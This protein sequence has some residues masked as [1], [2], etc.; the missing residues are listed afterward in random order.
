MLHQN[1]IVS[2]FDSVTVEDIKKNN[3]KDVSIQSLVEIFFHKHNF[4]IFFKFPA[5]S[6]SKQYKLRALLE[7]K[8]IGLR[9]LKKKDL[10]V[11]LRVY[12]DI[13]RLPLK[14][15]FFK[16]IRVSGYF[17]I[18]EDY[19]HL[20]YFENFLLSKLFGQKFLPIFLKTNTQFFF[21]NSLHYKQLRNKLTIFKHNFNNILGFFPFFYKFH[22]SYMLFVLYLRI[23]DLFY[24]I[25]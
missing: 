5:S 25:N 17:I 14:D 10:L 2:W 8:A 19:N 11:G 18:F 1:L 20:V 16:S 15:D 22:I 23:Q 12:K 9:Y 13:G 7:T 3:G 24:K 6:A 21:F 4:V